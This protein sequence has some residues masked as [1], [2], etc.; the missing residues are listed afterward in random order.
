MG[1]LTVLEIS[2][3]QQYIFKT[4]RLRENIGA[5]SIIDYV[6]ETLPD[7]YCEDAKGTLVNRGGGSSIFYFDD[8][9]QA[10][11]FNMALTKMLLKTY[12]GLEF[13]VGL[14]NYDPKSDRIMDAMDNLFSRLEQKKSTRMH[15]A[16]ITDLGISE[17]CASTRFPAIGLDDYGRPASAEILAKSNESHKQ[18]Q[19]NRKDFFAMSSEALGLARNEKAYMAITHIDGNRMGKRILEIKQQFSNRYG[20]EATELVNQAYVE[21]LN[22]FSKNIERAFKESFQSLVD[23]LVAQRSYLEAN[24]LKLEPDKIPIRKIILAGDDVCYVTDAR[25]AIECARIFIEKLETFE[26]EGEK[27]TACAGIAMVKDKFPFYKAY[28]LSENLC[29]NAKNAIKEDKIESRIDWQIMQGDFTTDIKELRA[30]THITKDKKNISLKPMIV[31]LD[32]EK[33]NNQHHYHYFVQDLKALGK[34]SMARGKVKGM[35]PVIQ[36][37]EAATNIYLNVNQLHPLIGS[38]RMGAMTGFI[39]E[40]CVLFDAIETMDYWIGLEGGRD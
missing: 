15:Y 21:A 19:A 35:L 12:P 37:G 9:D 27:I 11:S 22:K 38:H 40:G 30:R 6:T 8:H 13:F 32:K 26:L 10:V 18:S 25:I 28:Q 36:Q 2:K 29:R 4:N 16:G 33:S 3:K 39:E 14:Q 34:D 1:V 23:T 17:K 7:Q 5:S 20:K 31:S 24:G